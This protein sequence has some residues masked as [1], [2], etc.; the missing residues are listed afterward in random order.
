MGEPLLKTQD[1]KFTY[2]DYKTWPDD[3]RWELIDGEA[4]DMSHGCMGEQQTC[5]RPAPAPNITHQTISM[6][7]S[8]TIGSF[9]KGKPCRVFAAP[10]DVRLPDLE[11][12]N[13]EDIFTVVQP[14]LVVVC[15]ESKLDQRGCIG[16]PDLV[17]EILS[18]STSYKDE[19][20]KLKLYEKHGV[21]E[22]WIINPDAG[23]VLLHTLKGEKFETPIY[24]RDEGILE[25]SVLKGLKLSLNN[26][27]NR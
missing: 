9:L 1:R 8:V 26:L 22:Y 14:D 13:D 24:L 15:D 16:A 27:F 3:E 23:I 5:L 10:F 6:E 25:S 7:L 20:F 18:P 4:W 21:K 17:V 2:A 12:S 11:K 19:S